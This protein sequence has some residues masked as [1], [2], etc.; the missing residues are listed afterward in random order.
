[1]RNLN[2]KFNR[3]NQ[4]LNKPGGMPGVITAQDKIIRTGRNFGNNNLGDQ[5]GT[6]R[7]IY[8]TLPLDGKTTFRFFQGA[9][10][11]QFPFTNLNQDGGKL[12][13]GEAMAME[14][15][16]LNFFTIDPLTGAILGVTSINNNLN[17]IQGELTFQ[18]GNSIL[19][20]RMKLT[21]WASDFNKS[22]TFG[23]DAVTDGQTVFHF[24]TFITIQPL[25]EFVAEIN[26]PFQPAVADTYVQLVIE[27]TGAILSPKQNF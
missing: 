12:A 10:S 2:L 24:D 21:S 14:R 7:I 26:V 27:G 3:N 5:Q 16:Y 15:I 22:A 8:D 9:N 1:M 6:T 23:Q 19:I 18:Q 11:R 17:F 25:L 4:G 20:K 13:V